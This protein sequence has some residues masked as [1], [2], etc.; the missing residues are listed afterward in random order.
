MIPLTVP[1]IG[2]EEIAACQRVL[3]SGMLV[4][5]EEVRSFEAELA[6]MTRRGQAVAV[7]NGTAALELALRA[8]DI[9]PGDEVLCPALTWPS[10]AHAVL[11]VGATLVLVD[12]DG[13]EW[14]ATEQHFAAAR[15]ARTRAAIVIEQFGNPARHDAI[16]AA[17][18]GV[19]LI[20][21]A[22]C[23]LGA[24]YQGAPC[25]SHGV[26]ACTSFHPRK[27]LTTGEGGACL[28]DDDGLAE[29]LRSLR[30]HGQSAPGVFACASGNF[31]MTELA[32]AIGRVQLAKLEGLVGERQR[33]AAQIRDALPDVLFQRAPRAGVANGQT[34]GVL[35]A[36]SAD[37]CARR[38]RAIAT[39]RE[40]EV[41]AGPLSYALHLLPQFQSAAKRARDAGRTLEHARGVADRGLS[42]PLFPSMS[43]AQL[44]RVIAAVRSALV[45]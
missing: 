13:E 9:G 30:N 37:D 32:A 6:R 8:L 45:S 31:R 42:I 16:R 26:I 22:A 36:P 43:D 20:V 17:L 1:A 11:A 21:D 7:A 10:P 12:V 24:S 29:R 3:S 14:N 19:A 33:L 35:V 23:S 5:G 25:G 2:A 44:E 27:I 4:Q 38:D 34:L 41:Q 40:Q 15:S 28:T 18:P 39:M